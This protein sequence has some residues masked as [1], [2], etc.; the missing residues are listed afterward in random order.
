[1]ASHLV[2]HASVGLP[3][4]YLDPGRAT[5]GF[6]IG[7][8]AWY[9][10]VGAYTSSGERLDA[11]TATAAHSSLPLAS[12]AKVTNLDNGRSLVVKINDR[13]PRTRRFIIDLSPRAADELEVRHAGVAPV[14]VEPLASGPAD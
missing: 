9:N 11:I 1:M 2:A 7:K 8:A 12:F 13:G 14:I 3:D 6:E 5:G 10:R 4:A